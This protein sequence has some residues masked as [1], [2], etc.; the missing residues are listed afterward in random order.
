MKIEQSHV[1]T[2][3]KGHRVPTARQQ[4]EHASAAPLCQHQSAKGAC[5]STA[6][7]PPSATA[8]RFGSGWPRAR[9]EVPVSRSRALARASSRLAEIDA[10]EE[11]HHR[12][13]GQQQAKRPRVGAPQIVEALRPGE[14]ARGRPLPARFEPGR[15]GFSPAP[16]AVSA[17]ARPRDVTR[18]EPPDQPEPSRVG[19]VE[20]RHAGH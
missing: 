3:I 6:A 2:C 12:N 11:Q 14:H 19:R 16:C 18:G 1:E 20:Q 13:S 7:T 10:G 17:P 9:N 5:R 4:G 15:L 8:G